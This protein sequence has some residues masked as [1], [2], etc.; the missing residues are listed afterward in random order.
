MN[1]FVFSYE[2]FSNCP[3]HDGGKYHGLKFVRKEDEML[4]FALRNLNYFHIL[5]VI[6]LSGNKDIEFDYEAESH[7]Y[8][9]I[10]YYV[11]ADLIKRTV[12]NGSGMLIWRNENE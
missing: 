11:D 6:D 9:C 1:G 3:T 4:D 2:H 10:K 12:D 8:C 5:D 7:R